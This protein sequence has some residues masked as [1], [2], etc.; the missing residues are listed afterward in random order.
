MK[1]LVKKHF[2][3]LIPVY[4]SDAERL[5]DARL[6]EGEVYE[7]EIKHKRNIDFHRKYFALINLCFD[8]QD[9]FE[10]F[11]DLRE[12]L[13]IKAGYFKE[14]PTLDNNTKK[15]ALSI[16]FANMD[17][18]EFSDLYKKTIDAICKFID[19]EAKDIMNEI[20]EFM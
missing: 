5:K 4:N 8:N 12:E 11:E 20:V 13:I 18:I 10:D 9:T 15:K 6:K 14:V 16:S 17:D 1:F 19:V 7:V 2:G 3:K